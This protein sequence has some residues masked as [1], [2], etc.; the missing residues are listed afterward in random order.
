MRRK[1]AI[2]RSLKLKD[3]QTLVAVV[4]AGGMTGAARRL[5]TAQS[6]ISKSIANLERAL[7]KPLLDRSRRG[8]SL[9]SYGQVVF[10]CASSISERLRHGLNELAAL[11]DPAMG[12]VRIAASEPVAAAT[13]LKLISDFSKKSAKTR[14]VLDTGSPVEVCERLRT[15]QLDFAV[16]QV[17]RDLSLEGLDSEELQDDT[18]AVV[19]GSGGSLAKRKRLSITDLE[20]ARWVLPPVSSF[21][22]SQVR[23]AFEQAGKTAPPV[24]LTTHSG[25]MRLLAA[26]DA[27]FVT[28]I[29]KRMLSGSLKRI[30]VTELPIRL[31]LNSRP[32]CLL[33]RKHDALSS[34]AEAFIATLRKRMRIGAP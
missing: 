20:D 14:Y 8:A 7:D 32:V 13:V 33:R 21:I 4:E 10:D 9:T 26:A 29:P 6:A 34:A 18:L 17:F 22:A 31:P 5:Y 2:S 1:S 16:T 19:C 24:T 12:E 23:Q 28:V 25:V 15:K 11:D 3:L 30:P 27:D